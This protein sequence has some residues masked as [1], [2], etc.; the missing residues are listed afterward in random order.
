MYFFFYFLLVCLLMLHKS[1]GTYEEIHIHAAA[2]IPRQLELTLQT[3]LT[4]NSALFLTLPPKCCHYISTYGVIGHWDFWKMSVFQWHQENRTFDG[5]HAF[6]KKTR[7]LY[8]LP[9]FSRLA[10]KKKKKKGQ[11]NHIR[12]KVIDKENRHKQEQIGKGNR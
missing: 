10:Q 11:L 3:R 9:S 8:S 6:F 7:E 12:K 4:W 2:I 5:M 1:W